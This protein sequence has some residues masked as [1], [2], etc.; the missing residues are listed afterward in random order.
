[1]PPANTTN[2]EQSL[3]APPAWWG[4]LPSGG[5]EVASPWASPTSYWST[6]PADSD[7]A[8]GRTQLAE[9]SPGQ[10]YLMGTDD[11]PQW[12]IDRW[13]SPQGVYE[14]FA[15]L[16]EA[17]R[18]GEW[19]MWS[20]GEEMLADVQEG[21]EVGMGRLEGMLG[22]L[23]ARQQALADDPNRAFVM[24]ELARRAD[25]DYQVVTPQMRSAMDLQVAQSLARADAQARGG[26]GESGFQSSIDPYLTA[27]G[28][29]SGAAITA[30]TQIA[31][32][33]A[34]ARATSDLNQVNFDWLRM[35]QVIG[36]TI[37]EG[38]RLM[39]EVEMDVPLLNIDP[40]MTTAQTL[41]RES[42][43]DS[44][45]WMERQ[46]ALMEQQ[47]E[48]GWDDWADIGMQLV[49]AYPGA[50]SDLLFGG[51]GGQESSWRT[52]YNIFD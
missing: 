50:F 2:P 24:E 20:L 7:S 21:R 45:D 1:M 25:P 15:N 41:A 8:I 37:A 33:E 52:N 4:G 14:H 32:E 40:W 17:N 18:E 38:N 12:A 35:D 3:Y 47:A 31:N 30:Q 48:W 42:Y 51:G 6:D 28:A 5:G 26:T 22:D 9:G 13:G 11:T 27:I 16:P 43:D 34:R 46:V 23:Q 29:A 49:T 44:Q 19:L 39:A 10:A 36:D